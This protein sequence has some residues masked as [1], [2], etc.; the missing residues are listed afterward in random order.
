MGVNINIYFMQFISNLDN[1]ALGHPAPEMEAKTLKRAKSSWHL[2]S[3]SKLKYNNLWFY[4]TKN[5]NWMET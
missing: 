1:L 4:G 2:G 3:L 5:V